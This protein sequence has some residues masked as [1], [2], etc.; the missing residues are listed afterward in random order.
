MRCIFCRF[1]SGDDLPHRSPNHHADCPDKLGLTDEE[2]KTRQKHFWLG[3]NEAQRL[4]VM[5]AD[6]KENPQYSMGW[7]EGLCAMEERENG[8]N[9]FAEGNDP[10]PWG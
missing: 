1:E 2:K 3:H 10:G 7:G 5:P 6:G 9:P 4:D 8:Y